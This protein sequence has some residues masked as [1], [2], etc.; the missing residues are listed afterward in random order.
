MSKE[1]TTGGM[2]HSRAAAGMVLVTLAWSIAGVV[3]RHL[4]AAESFEV[5]FW[6]SSFCFA[7]LGVVLT[8]M[9]GPSLWSGLLRSPRAVWFSGACW[10]VMFTAFMIA[11]TLTRV[12]N[13]LVTMSIGPLLTALFARLFLKRR[14][15]AR[16]WVAI[17]VA[18]VG[19]AWMFGRGVQAADA[20]SLGGMLVALAVPL[21]A[22]LNWT[23]LHHAAPGH[24][25]PVS[26]PSVEEAG[27]GTVSPGT[28]D[29]SG[30]GH[31][32]LPAVMIGAFVSALVTAPLAWPLQATAHDLGLLALLGVVQLA[33]PCLLVVRL[34]RELPS[35]E[36]SLLGLLEVVFGVLWAWVGAGEAP[37]PTAL[38][39][40]AL[41]IGALVA[42][43]LLSS[44]ARGR[45]TASTPSA[46]DPRPSARRI[47]E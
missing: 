28:P 34:T 13:V 33:L 30:P 4:E 35:H 39:G 5:T 27:E 14:L 38:T 19:I 20:R 25:A 21:A 29:A 41:V 31:D 44:T 26:S 8:A 11:L 36:I 17:A 18:G 2:S 42:N 43:E 32:M 23:V 40:G 24:A 37:G 46:T 22:A 45:R 3:T 10:A 6:R 1:S 16:T 15:P 12:A 9:R 47:P 7:C